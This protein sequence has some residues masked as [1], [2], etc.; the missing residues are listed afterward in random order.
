MNVI[1]KGMIELL[2]RLKEEYGV[3]ELKAEYEN[4]GSRPDELMRLK[5]V[6][7]NVGLPVILKIGG[8]EA[9]SDIYSAITLGAKGVIAPMAETKFAVSKF[10]NAITNF[11]PT[12]NASDIDFCINVE[13]ITAHN[14]IDEI[15]SLADISILDGVTIGRVD[16]TASMGKD[17][18]FVNSPEMLQ[19][20]VNV[21]TK[22]REKN[23]KCGLGGAI[24]TESEGFIRH[25]VERN[26]VDKFETRKVVYDKSALDTLQEGI[27]LGVEFE[28]RWLESKERYYHRIKI[29][30]QKR[31]LMLKNR[32]NS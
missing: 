29:E 12:D 17:R 21:F 23:L 25:L 30:D 10:T 5:D 4:E 3:I 31:I 22:C 8:V 20:C 9:V 32:L 27:L 14:N 11:V 6:A 7:G 19:Y 16:F 28:L 1:E 26:L 2:K 13:T 18:G 15:L 24:S